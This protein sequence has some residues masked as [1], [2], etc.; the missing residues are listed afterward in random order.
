MVTLFFIFFKNLYSSLLTV[1]AHNSTSSVSGPLLSTPLSRLSLS[2]I[3]GIYV[4][5]LRMHYNILVIDF[6]L[7]TSCYA[8][9]LAV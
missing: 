2:S 1:L 7:L 4:Y 9:N 8:E 5:M 3:F 6:C